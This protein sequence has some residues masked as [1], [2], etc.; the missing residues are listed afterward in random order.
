MFNLVRSGLLMT[1]VMAG[2]IL[3]FE[4]APPEFHKF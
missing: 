2:P 1:P 4:D 3:T